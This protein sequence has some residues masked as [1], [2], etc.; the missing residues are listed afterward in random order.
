MATAVKAPKKVYRALLL[1]KR[2]EIL[3]SVK[4]EPDEALSANI[5]T[6]DEGE[7]AKKAA[8]QAVAAATMDLRFRLL[9][10]IDRALDRVHGGTYGAC[11]R[12][13][14]EILP[15]RL[16]AIPWARYCLS[17]EEGRSKN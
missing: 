7:F 9:K 16:R 1:K 3:V 6:P 11:E 5:R 8:D 17:C 4:A 2:E 15:H 13:G 12:C 10:E 14:E